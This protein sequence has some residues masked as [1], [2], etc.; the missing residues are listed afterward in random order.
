MAQLF[1]G[2]SGYDYKEWKGEGLFYPA[3]L[4]GTKFLDYYA[5]RYNSLEFHG[6]F[7]QMLSETSVNNW[8]GRTP[9]GFRVAAKMNQV[10]THFKRLKPESLDTIKLYC[11]RLRPAVEADKL[12]TVYLQLPPNLKRD[13]ELLASF[14]S[15]LPP[16]R[17][18][19]EFQNETW[20]APEV[21]EILRRHQVAWVATQTDETEAQLRD[22]ADHVYAR[23]RK[24]DYTDDE[25]KKWAEYFSAK[26]AE[27]RDCY[28]FCR[29]KDTVAPWRW[30]DRIRE[31]VS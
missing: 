6:A 14:L 1:L 8:I 18:S 12:G 13:D 4:A 31:L 25:L 24:L 5:T 26:I 2:L 29:H 30:A 7:K 27:G 16:H 23:L 28:V 9:D 22:T 15:A 3:D 21:E 11:E 10:V 19:I 20:N 17:W